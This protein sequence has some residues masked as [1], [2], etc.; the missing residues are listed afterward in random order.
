MWYNI[1]MLE[2]IEKIK[3]RGKIEPGFIGIYYQY[4]EDYISNFALANKELIESWKKENKEQQPG[5]VSTLSIL[6]S[7][8]GEKLTGLKILD[9]GCGLNAPVDRILKKGGANI[10]GCDPEPG[11]YEKFLTKKLRHPERPPVSKE[12]SFPVYKNL[13]EIPQKDKLFDSVISLRFFGFPLLWK[14]G[15]KANYSEAQGEKYLEWLNKY[16][17]EQTRQEYLKQ[18]ANI[19]EVTKDKGI[20]IIFFQPNPDFTISSEGDI[21]SSL[22]ITK[23]DLS[24]LGLYLVRD[25]PSG[26]VEFYGSDDFLK[27]IS[28]DLASEFRET[29][30]LQ[31]D[32]DLAKNRII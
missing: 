32:Y 8:Y 24:K 21:W 30:I 28:R 2:N 31:R 19:S 18:L 3:K 16:D 4:E 22:M 17:F 7:I 26:R 23:D 6:H 29:V 11:I 14:D 20:I 5:V 10:I 1:I 27:S 13:G 25:R 12:L 15:E 9:M